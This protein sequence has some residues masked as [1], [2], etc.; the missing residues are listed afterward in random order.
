MSFL[1]FL[2][3][4]MCANLSVEVMTRLVTERLT[5]GPCTIDDLARKVAG[6]DLTLDLR[7]AQILAQAGVDSLKEGGDVLVVDGGISLARPK[8]MV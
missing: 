4:D 3:D 1:Q 6:W 7:S 2:I 5:E 8:A